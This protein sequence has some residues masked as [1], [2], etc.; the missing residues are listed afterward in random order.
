MYVSVNA[1][2]HCHHLSVAIMNPA[3]TDDA[4]ISALMKDSLPGDMF[5]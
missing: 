2:S 3:V 1:S 4:T 5:F